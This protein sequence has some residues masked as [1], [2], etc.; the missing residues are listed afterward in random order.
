MAR[1]DFV[2]TASLLNTNVFL[3]LSV[4]EFFRTRDRTLTTKERRISFLS[5]II[6]F[7]AG[8][9]Y[10]ILEVNK[11]SI[12]TELYVRY[13]DWL[14]TTPL[15]LIIL[16]E[17]YEIPRN[18]VLHWVILDIIMVVSGIL[19]EKTGNVMYW[20]IGTGSYFILLALLSMQLPEYTL[21]I[22]FFVFGWSGY[23]IVSRIDQHYRS[24]YYNILDFYN[25]AV[26]AIVV[27]TMNT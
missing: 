20:N 27:E 22:P 17:Q 19:Y 24:M 7:I 15:L 10:G 2:R 14:L 21:F 16:G 8:V 11:P 18:T 1:L 4:R 26:F 3:T 9:H 23:G 13:S 25:K 12:Q 6:L 5:M